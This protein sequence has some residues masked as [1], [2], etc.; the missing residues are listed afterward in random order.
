VADGLPRETADELSKEFTEMNITIGREQGAKNVGYLCAWCAYIAKK[1]FPQD[2]NLHYFADIPL[3]RLK[4]ETLS[5]PRTRVGYYRGCLARAPIFAPGALKEFD[6]NWSAYREVLDRIDGLEVVDMPNNVCCMQEEKIFK[7]AKEQGLS[8][9]VTMCLP[10]HGR[11]MRK[12]PEDIQIIG[13][14]DLML[15]AVAHPR[16]MSLFP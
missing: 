8:T 14:P 7:F 3:Q 9:I 4:E 5:L 2:S 16:K 6:M 1:Y 13:W 11:L 10:C 12:T 15:M